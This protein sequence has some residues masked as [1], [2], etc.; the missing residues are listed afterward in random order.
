MPA[1]LPFIFVAGTLAADLRAFT[2]AGAAPARWVGQATA[3]ILPAFSAFDVKAQ[4]VHGL[5]VPAAY[6]IARRVDAAVDLLRTSSEKV[7]HIARAVG[8]ASRK[9]FNRALARATGQRPSDLR[10]AGPSCPSS[11]SRP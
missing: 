5:G 9:N 6:L 4:V 3:A 10:R 8:W 1:A 2:A 7:E 11:P